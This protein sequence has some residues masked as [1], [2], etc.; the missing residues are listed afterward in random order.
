MYLS[1]KDYT[2]ISVY[3][4]C[5]YNNYNNRNKLLHNAFNKNKHLFRDALECLISLVNFLTHQPF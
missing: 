4:F 2:I 1:T 3:E 5:L